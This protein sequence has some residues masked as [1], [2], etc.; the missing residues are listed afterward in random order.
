MKQWKKKELKY[1]LK[2][3]QIEFFSEIDPIPSELIKSFKKAKRKWQYENIKILRLALKQ[4]EKEFIKSMQ[5]A[6][7]A[8]NMCKA[9]KNSQ[10]WNEKIIN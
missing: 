3:F 6:K 7:A 5:T 1:L 9:I 4:N 2:Q 10:K 8:Y